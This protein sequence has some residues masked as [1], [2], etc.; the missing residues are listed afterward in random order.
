MCFRGIEKAR[1]H[2]KG[3]ARTYILGHNTLENTRMLLQLPRKQTYHNK[4]K[5]I[6]AMISQWSILFCTALA[7]RVYS[8][9]ALFSIE[10]S[11]TCIYI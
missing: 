10:Y 3:I 5:Y 11:Y 9:D 6:L 7:I 4:F 8:I 2:L 1:S